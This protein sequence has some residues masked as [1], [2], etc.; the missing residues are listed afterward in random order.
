MP[1]AKGKK[2]GKNNKGKEK[3]KGN[4]KEIEDECPSLIVEVEPKGGPHDDLPEDRKVFWTYKEAMDDE[5]SIGRTGSS[6]TMYER[7]NRLFS[8]LG[9]SAMSSHAHARLLLTGYP[10]PPPSKHTDTHTLNHGGL[11]S[12]LWV[13]CKLLE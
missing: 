8:R 13:A 2:A 11:P 10:P 3:D 1:P 6:E 7:S 9:P 4:H 12:L 5:A